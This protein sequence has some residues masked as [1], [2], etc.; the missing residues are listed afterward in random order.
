LLVARY[1]AARGRLNRDLDLIDRALDL[2]E[3]LYWGCFDLDDARAEVADFKR[4]C[5]AWR[6]QR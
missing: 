3:M 5:L 1:R 6:I 4:R 2:R